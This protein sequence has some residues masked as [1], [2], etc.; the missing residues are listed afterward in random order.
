MI[1]DQILKNILACIIIFMIIMIT[2]PRCSQ[3]PEFEPIYDVPAPYILLV[4]TFKYE[5]QIRG[6]ELH[7]NN[8]IVSIDE[9]L[10]FGFCGTCNSNDIRGDIQKVISIN[11]NMTCWNNYQEQ[12]A[13][14]FHELGHCVLG[15]LHLEDTFAN[16]APKSLMI[17]NNVSVYSPCVY[18]IGTVD[19]CNLTKRRQYYI[20]ELFDPSTPAPLWSIN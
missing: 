12:E 16:G 7:L 20:D 14:L 6:F 1:L 5:A 13:F 17:S 8:L 3:K 2:L 19:D 4:D 9:T 18:Q 11:P 10:P 15:R